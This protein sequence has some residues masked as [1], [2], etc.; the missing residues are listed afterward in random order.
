MCKRISLLRSLQ[1]FKS[2]SLPCGHLVCA[3]CISEI[4]IHSIAANQ[5]SIC[6]MC[7]CHIFHPPVP[8]LT[9][10]QGVREVAES[11]GLAVPPFCALEWPSSGREIPDVIEVLDHGVSALSSSAITSATQRGRTRGFAHNLLSLFFLSAS[12][13]I[14]FM[15]VYHL[16]VW[17]K[18]AVRIALGKVSL[19]D[20]DAIV[21]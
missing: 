12:H 20:E 14:S 2:C 7:R 19:I 4:R 10:R 6:P 13:F 21:H 1:S 18:I 11:L 3:K 9:I 5:P 15:A 17:A 8:S 16:V